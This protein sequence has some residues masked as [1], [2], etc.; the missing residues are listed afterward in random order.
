L[1]A[2]PKD[3]ELN[4]Y[5][6]AYFGDRLNENQRAVVISNIHRSLEKEHGMAW[7]DSIASYVRGLL[8]KDDSTMASKSPEEVLLDEASTVASLLVKSTEEM[9]SVLEGLDGGFIKPAPG[10]GKSLEIDYVLRSS[11]CST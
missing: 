2:V 9:D 10:G 6:E 4:S 3:E 5:L 1:G 11:I 7:F 8:G